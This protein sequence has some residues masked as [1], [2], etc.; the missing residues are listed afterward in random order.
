MKII[1]IGLTLFLIIYYLRYKKYINPYKLVMVF[2]KKGSGKTTFLIKQGIYYQKKGYAVY[3]NIDDCTLPNI[4][5]IDINDLGNFVPEQNSV[6]LLDEA[7]IIFDNRNWKRFTEEKRDF[8]KYQRH[9]KVICFLASQTYDID[10]KLRD[11]CDSLIL[12]QNIGIVYTLV[13]PI[14]KAITLTEAVAEGESRIAENLKFKSPLS[15]K[16]FKNIKYSRYFDSYVIPEKPLIKYTL[17]ETNSKL[18]TSKN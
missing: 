7:G 9:Y 13:R 11:L 15:W 1:I 10:S 14:R 6:L 8:F 5:I 16:I 18:T 12:V 2:G 17:S 3:T 4:R